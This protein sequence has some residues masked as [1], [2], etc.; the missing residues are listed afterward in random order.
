VFKITCEQKIQISSFF[1]ASAKYSVKIAIHIDD[2]GMVEKG[3]LFY[4]RNAVLFSF[5]FVHENK[6]KNILYGKK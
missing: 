5:N 6:S 2:E 4:N 1:Y 3:D